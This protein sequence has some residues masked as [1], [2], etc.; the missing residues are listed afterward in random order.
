M[1]SI[2]PMAAGMLSLVIAAGTAAAQQQEWYQLDRQDQQF[3]TR[4]FQPDQQRWRTTTR[5]PQLTD[6]EMTLAQVG[7]E[8]HTFVRIEDGE[9]VSAY[10]D[11]RLVPKQ[12]VQVRGDRIRILDHSGEPAALFRVPTLAQMLASPERFDASLRQDQMARMHE[13]MRMMQQQMGGDG[14]GQMMGSPDH[15]AR[16]QERMEMMQQQ[17]GGRGM[18]R[19][20]GSPQMPVADLSTSAIGIVMLEPMPHHLRGTDFDRGVYIDAVQEG[21]P[22]HQAG[23]RQGDI[24]VAVDGREGVTPQRLKNFLRNVRPGETLELTIIR[25]GRE[26]DLSVRTAE[27]HPVNVNWDYMVT[28]LDD[29]QLRQQQMMLERHRQMR[30][31]QQGRLLGIGLSEA[32][33]EALEDL[34]QFEEGLEVTHIT[35]G[36]MLHQAGLRRG[37][38]IV[39]AD[40][41]RDLSKDDLKG[42]LSEKNPGETVHLRIWRDGRM[43]SVT[44]PIRSSG[45]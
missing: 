29:R 45:W 2:R 26:R 18:G 30:G 1:R 36:T 42:I 28:G 3:T 25:D 33:E 16:M 23:L 22:A 41:Q 38:I 4:G 17:M 14:M 15:M 13:H 7:Q 5:V 31:F 19:M 37:D 8:Q 40:G 27:V 6:V 34:E 9:I 24:I 10:V 21:L 39:S 12:N 20:M 11:G 44:V 35:R 32:D 43:Q